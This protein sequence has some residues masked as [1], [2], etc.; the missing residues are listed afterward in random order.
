[1][2][3][4]AMTEIVKTKSNPHLQAASWQTL[5]AQVHGH[6]QRLQ[7]HPARTVVLLPFFQLQ[8]VARVSSRQHWPS[9][10]TPR[11]ETTKSWSQRISHFIPGELDISFDVGLD[12]L[13]ASTWLQRAGLGAKQGMLASVLVDTARAAHGM[14]RAGPRASFARPGGQPAGVRGRCGPHSAGVGYRIKLRQRRAV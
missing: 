14:G 5:W 7:A 13:R 8:A 9:G 12:S 2:L 11:L 4:N 10:F 3:E 6:M 1:V